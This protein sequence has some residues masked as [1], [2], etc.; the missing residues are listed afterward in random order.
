MSENNAKSIKW[1]IIGAGD[2]CEVKS[3]PALQNVEGSALVAV[4]RR[5][6]A[7][8]EDFAK[9]HNVPRWYSDADDLIN[10]PEVNAVYIA[11]PPNTHQYYAL[12]VAA[13][14]KIVY[15][16]KPMALN[17]AE[18]RTMIEACQ[19]A[20]VPLYVAFYRRA[21]PNFLKIE[22]L[23]KEKAIG[24]VRFV[25]I[26]LYKSL[27]PDI[28]GGSASF[29]NWRSQPEI[30]GGGY[31][32]DLACHQLD[33]LDYLFG[34]I[35]KANGISKNQAG[36]Y[37][38][39][40]IVIGNFEFASGVL[41]TGTWCFSVAQTLEIEKTTIVGSKGQIS[42]AYFGDHSVLLEIEG[43]EPQKFTF[44][45]SKHIQQPFIQ[46]MIDELNGIGQCQSKGD[47][48]ARTSWVMDKI[49]GGA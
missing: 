31:F 42:F 21:L 10:D 2:V 15:V 46:T 14:G 7:L 26:S 18:A 12:K 22:E 24:D 16:E 40:D 43:K 35:V 4:M 37:H 3:G 23:L 34:P 36:A 17:F 20:N 1:G 19:K 29:N 11:T 28:V 9:R 30:A 44:G 33:A 6:G 47:S 48:A 5:N 25:N 38:A 39:D 49:C 27:K 45:I 41:G 32:H 8:A 13:A